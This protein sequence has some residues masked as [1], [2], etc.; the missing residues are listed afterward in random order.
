[1]FLDTIDCDTGDSSEAKHLPKDL[2]I[3]VRNLKR[4]KFLIC[5]LVQKMLGQCLLDCSYA[6]DLQRLTRLS[7]CSYQTQSQESL[8]LVSPAS[9]TEQQSECSSLQAHKCM[10]MC[11]TRR[12]LL[13]QGMQHEL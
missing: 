10:H 7:N 3:I 8:S 6:L 2:I 5:R 11:R 4:R 9:V 13:R 1:M 12:V